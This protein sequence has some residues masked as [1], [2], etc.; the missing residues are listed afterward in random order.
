MC[1]V[2]CY[3]SS[4]EKL[5]TFYQRADPYTG[6]NI[7]KRKIFLC[8]ANNFVFLAKDWYTYLL[9]PFI[10]RHYMVFFFLRNGL[11]TTIC[12]SVNGKFKVFL[13]KNIYIIDTQTAHDSKRKT[14]SC[15]KNKETKKENQ[16]LKTFFKF[17][18]SLS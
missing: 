14:Y 10:K 6:T 18:F 5:W 2:L 17:F 4:T 7:W 11:T 8:L 9:T 16:H 12:V 15:V 1:I 13:F 3:M